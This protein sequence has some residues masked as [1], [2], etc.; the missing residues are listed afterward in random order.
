MTCLV[1]RDPKVEREQRGWDH[2]YTCPNCGRFILARPL[3]SGLLMN[4]LERLTEPERSKLSLAMRA[5]YD[6]RQQ[7]VRLTIDVVE[8]VLDTPTPKP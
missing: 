1:C 3:T 8:S 5:E 6:R 2:V 4:R 7:E